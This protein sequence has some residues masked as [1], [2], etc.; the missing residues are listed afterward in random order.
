MCKSARLKSTVTEQLVKHCPICGTILRENNG[1]T[2]CPKGGDDH[3]VQAFER[4]D[5]TD[6]PPRKV[7]NL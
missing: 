7:R 5:M 4:H 2:T 6:P 1:R 3:I